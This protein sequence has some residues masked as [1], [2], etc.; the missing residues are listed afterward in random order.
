MRISDDDSKTQTSIVVIEESYHEHPCEGDAEEDP[1]LHGIEY[2]TLSKWRARGPR[3]ILSAS[4]D[5]S[6]MNS[7]SEII[8]TATAA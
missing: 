8:Y 1:D 5:C 2:D 6:I 3:R 7:T 4:C